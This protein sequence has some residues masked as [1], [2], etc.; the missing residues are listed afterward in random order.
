MEIRKIKQGE[1]AQVAE[2]WDRVC[3]ET[4]DGGLL[5]DA[6]RH[7]ITHMLEVAAWHWDE[8]CLVAV[9]DGAPIGFV[10]LSVHGGLLPGVVGWVDELHVL[11][12]PGDTEIRRALLD[13]AVAELRAAGA[14]V[15]R[16]HVDAADQ[17][18]RAFWTGRGFEA[19][20]IVCSLYE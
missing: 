3:R 16:I 10:L 7:A 13:A 19:D 20:M 17:R 2:L 4:P 1:G 8:R 6:G 14:Q 11:R 18:E 12:Q 5:T 9:R 15:I